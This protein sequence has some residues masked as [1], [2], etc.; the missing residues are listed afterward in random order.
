MSMY[1]SPY[2]SIY[3]SIFLPFYPSMYLC[4]YVCIYRSKEGPPLALDAESSARGIRVLPLGPH[5]RVEEE[6]SVHLRAFRY[7]R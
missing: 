7:L 3:L 6:G 4:I 1:L 5:A 2:L